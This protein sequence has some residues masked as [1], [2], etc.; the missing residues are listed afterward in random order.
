MTV[1]RLTVRCEYPG[2]DSPPDEVSFRLSPSY[3][4]H[5]A[6]EA[7]EW[8]L[9]M[10][11]AHDEFEVET[12]VPGEWPI[13]VCSETVRQVMVWSQN[14]QLAL[15]E[16][17][18]VATILSDR[19]T[20]MRPILSIAVLVLLAFGCGGGSDPTTVDTPTTDDPALPPPS[21]NI[22]GVD[23]FHVDPVEV[24]VFGDPNFLME[25][26][27]GGVVPQGL[28]PSDGKL[29]VLSVKDVT[30]PDLIC[31]T[32]NWGP[33]CA[34]MI[35]IEQEGRD[36]GR[37]PGRLELNTSGGRKIWFPQADTLTLAEAPPPG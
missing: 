27:K 30:D 3:G 22:I 18:V 25:W 29:L 37:L 6:R 23:S 13:P 19:G 17:C 15:P 7:H 31:G 8:F 21:T 14:P 20:N 16:E 2:S 33:T 24:R 5:N 1:H 9:K 10:M 34:S 28:V 26:A 32:G 12:D 36:P 11:H 4:I 35:L